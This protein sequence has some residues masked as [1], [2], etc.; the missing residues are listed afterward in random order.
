MMRTVCIVFKNLKRLRT[1]RQPL[2]IRSLR[3]PVA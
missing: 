2:A 3:R 1:G